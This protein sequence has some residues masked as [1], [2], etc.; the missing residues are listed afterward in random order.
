MFDILFRGQRMPGY[1]FSAGGGLHGDGTATGRALIP[2]H[3]SDATADWQN[4]DDA[5]DDL[6]AAVARGDA[7]APP[8][9]FPRSRVVRR[10]AELRRAPYWSRRTHA[11]ADLL[12]AFYLF[13][14]GSE[15]L[16]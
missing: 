4:P 15:L 8:Q 16:R 12:E 10:I 7:G 13:G 6:L 9:S 14:D 5:F 3:S 1:N 2:R 11:L